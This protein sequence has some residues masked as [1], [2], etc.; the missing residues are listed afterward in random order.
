MQCASCQH[1]NPAGQKFCGECGAPLVA[2][3]SVCPSCGAS[4]ALDQ[5]FCAE[6]GTS[7]GRVGE[8]SSRYAA[9]QSY[10]PKHLAEKIRI[11]KPAL[12]GERKQVTV[13]FAD[14]KNSMELLR[15]RDPEEAGR[16]LDP[17]LELMMEAVHHYEGTVNQVMGDG[18]MALFGAPLAHEDHAVRACY[19]ALRMQ[20]SVRRHA[21]S[22]PPSQAAPIQIRI[23]LNS[24]EVVVRSIGNDLR[25]DYSAV[26][27]TTHMAARMEQMAE[28]GSILATA[29]TLRLAEGYVRVAYLG[30][31]PIRGLDA[32][33]DV[34]AIVGSGAARWR[35]E[36]AAARGFTDFVGRDAE[37]AQL[38]LARQSAAAG[39]GQAIG[40]VG[41]PGVGKSRL[42]HEFAQ[43]EGMA[44]WLV[45]RTAATSYGKATAYQAI[46]DL[47][48][49]Y[50]QPDGP[51]DEPDLRERITARTL[52]LDPKLSAVLPALFSLLDVSGDDDA[53]W[54]ALAPRQ[55]RQR[56]MDAVTQLLLAASRVQP[57]CLVFEDLHWIDSETQAFLDAFIDRLP[58]ARILLLVNY[59]PEYRHDWGSKTCYAQ[60]RIDPLPAGSAEALLR[61]LVGDD[62]ALA[63]LTR[64]L[65]ERTHG[66]PFFLEESVR[67]LA[68]NGVLVGER[69][70]HRLGHAMPATLL[71]ATV[72]AVLA[73]RID[74]LEPTDKRLLQ[75]ASVI[76]EHVPVALLQAVTDLAERELRDGLAR[77]RAA[78]FLHDITLF[79]DP[80]YVFRHGL[81][82][83]V[84]YNSLLREQRCLLH[85]RTVEA[86]ERLHADR[87]GEHIERLAHHARRGELWDRA[88]HY[89]RRAGAKAFARSANREAA[90]WFEQ[91]L[92]VLADLPETP[93][94]QAET[95]ETL[96]DLRNALTLLGQHER[97]LQYLRKAHTLAERLGDQ[98]QLGRALSFEVNCL[99]LLGEHERAIDCAHRARRVAEELG[100]LRLRT[101]T[102]MYAG[103]AHLHRGDFQRAIEIFGG[104]VDTLTG[105][106]AHD[107]LGVPV[108]PSVFARSHLVEALVETGQFAASQRYADEALALAQST[109]H[110]DTVLWAYHGAGLHH[111]ARGEIAAA[112]D[113]FQR[114]YSVCREH[115]MPVYRPR[116]SS[117]LG[118]A[119]ALGG[120]AIEAVPMV[121]QAAAE[122]AGR[123]QILSY[124]QVLL[125][126]AQ[127]CLLADRVAEGADVGA[128]A[129]AHFRRQGE[130]GHAAHA[131][132]VLGDIT[133]RQRPA[134]AARAE[135]YYEEAG[136]LADELGMRPLRARCRWSVA[137][138]LGETGRA[139]R[140]RRELQAACA[141]FRELGM[142]ADLARAEIEL[143]AL[144]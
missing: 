3:V 46:V 85:A 14:L 32:P 123:G 33:I 117:E 140:A 13:L 23:G 135:A 62:P 22:C 47:L 98:G 91:A 68:E 53:R 59:R 24:G 61:N 45:L 141:G 52:A 7:L 78:E 128:R 2:V 94:T 107:H 15:D 37:L 60:L 81:T 129:L 42:V 100:D 87:L 122:A 118:V 120:R 40:V 111:L 43:S 88:A 125:L 83:Q 56:T 21:E 4:T 66:N 132:W 41:E 76:G 96:L 26:G 31:Q 49:A 71:P 73:A 104:I 8:G 114:A 105:P 82:R 133:A 144:V 63:E 9:P 17:V 10:T 1:D 57:V 103:R 35:L 121:Q 99:F 84:A 51:N 124:S 115:D 30:Q 139:D 25:T 106:L 54:R 28:P 6:C 109:H 38:R 29:A 20:D 58:T 80:E 11:S 138:L 44:G 48:R 67:T 12:E 36:A 134:D 130:R 72:Q 65:I 69:G 137:R 112:T 95:V 93:A 34:Y 55:R 101:V 39:R 142:T 18:I 116:V 27:Q 70:R 19:A 90:A 127:V 110:P 64:L 119:W 92:D 97:T 79:A 102:D 16:M 136:A 86:I 75:C 143:A 74:R 89:L 5:K 108:L 113:A 77:L 131:L 50:F 126:L